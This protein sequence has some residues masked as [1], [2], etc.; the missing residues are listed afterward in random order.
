ML[1]EHGISLVLSQNMYGFHDVGVFQRAAF[2]SGSGMS[3]DYL[4]IRT[5]G[6]HVHN[7]EVVQS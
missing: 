6:G 2:E 5:P 7:F 1:T 3:A 4:R